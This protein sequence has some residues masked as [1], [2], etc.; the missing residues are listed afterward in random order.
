MHPNAV[1]PLLAMRVTGIGRILPPFLV[2]RMF[3]GVDRHTVDKTLQQTV[4]F[5]R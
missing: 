1:D 5:I 2:H 3:V 4:N